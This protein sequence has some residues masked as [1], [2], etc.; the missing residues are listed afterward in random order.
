M[1]AHRPRKG[2]SNVA[3][4]IIMLPDF[5]ETL[6]STCHDDSPIGSRFLFWLCQPILHPG[7]ASKFDEIRAERPVV[8]SDFLLGAQAPSQVVWRVLAPHTNLCW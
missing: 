8:A 4:S 5:L 1:R 6:R 2:M 3:E 7:D